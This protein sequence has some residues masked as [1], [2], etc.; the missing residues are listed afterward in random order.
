M[1]T[2]PK[3][4]LVGVLTRVSEPS[5]LMSA[6]EVC[7]H[8]RNTAKMSIVWEALARKLYPPQV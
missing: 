2:L 1:E 3:D 5:T 6:S 4:A 7:K 8:W